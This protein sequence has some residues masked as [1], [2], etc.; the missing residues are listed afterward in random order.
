MG[1]SITIA[2]ALASAVIL[3]YESPGTHD[4]ILRSQIRDSP[5][6]E[7]QV[8]VFISLRNK[9]DRLY[10]QALGFPFRRLL[11]YVLC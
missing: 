6:L 11:L 1:L 7:D 5:N 4:H 8:P 9:V 2:A 3:R 10:P